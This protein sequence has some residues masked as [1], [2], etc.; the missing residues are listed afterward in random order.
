MKAIY[1][2]ALALTLAPA[3]SAVPF[4]DARSGGMAGVGVASGD[5]TRASQNPA[6]LTR[7][8][9]DDDFYFQLG[10]GALARDYEEVVDDIDALQANLDAFEAL[11]DRGDPNDLPAATALKDEIIGQL[12]ALDQSRPEGA[13]GALLGFYVPSKSLGFGLSVNGYLVG[14]GLVN[15]VQE[16]EQLLD[17]ALMGQPFDQD[18]IQSNADVHAVGVTEVALSFAREFQ[19][20]WLGQFSVGVA[21][22]FQRIDTYYYNATV[23]NFDEDD[24]TSNDNMTDRSDFNLDI[25]FHGG[26]GPW[27]FGLVGRN[28]IKQNLRNVN[29]EDV[30]LKPTLT[31]AAAFQQG[32]FTAALDL[33]LI[34]D[35]SFALFAESRQWARFGVEYDFGGHAQLR[36]GY[37]HDL[38]GN[39]EDVLAVGL[40]I[41]P[42]D[43]FTL[44]LAGQFGSDDERGAQLQLG[45]KF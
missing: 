19:S 39:Y 23:S 35:E 4:A 36:A 27:Q 6:L 3:V 31:G 22:K 1:L 33:D 18:D 34:A 44:D 29:H 24:I 5:F 28:L 8:E 42:G 13:A 10:A 15:Y 9:A 2:G 45:L 43:V 12:N 14:N 41:S 25:G 37:R 11:I 38:E 30:E 17:D 16:D 20:P 32:G 40:G 26:H 7:F 21:P